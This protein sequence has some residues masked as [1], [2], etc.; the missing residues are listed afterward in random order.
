MKRGLGDEPYPVGQPSTASD[1]GRFPLSLAL[2]RWLV[3]EQYSRKK[4]LDGANHAKHM[5][6]YVGEQLDVGD[7]RA[8]VVVSENPCLIAAYS[9]DFDGVLMLRYEDR[10][11]ERFG[12]E[13]G[14]RLVAVFFYSLGKHPEQD[15]ILG[16]ASTNMF[17]G[18]HPVIADLLPTT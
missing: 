3:P 5:E 6:D 2:L 16:P 15:I 12:L 14:A 9:D 1:P 11:R 10:V 13:L 7:S 8:A 4:R 18:C 17:S